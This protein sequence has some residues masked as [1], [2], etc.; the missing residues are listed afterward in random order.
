MTVQTTGSWLNDLGKELGPDRQRRD[1]VRRAVLH[2]LR[3]RLT[4]D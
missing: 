3:D 1:H 2:T 4:V